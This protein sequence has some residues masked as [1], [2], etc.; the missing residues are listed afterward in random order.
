MT[1][2]MLETYWYNISM[3]LWIKKNPSTWVE[4]KEIWVKKN[5]STWVKAKQLWVKKT[6]NL[7]TMFWPQAGPYPEEELYVFTSLDVFPS[8]GNVLPKITAYVYRFIF[9]GTLTLKYRWEYSNSET[10]PFDPVSGFSTYQTY[11]PGN[12]ASGTFNTLDFIPQL[13]DYVYGRT[14]FR[15]V[16]QATDS[17]AT[18]TYETFSVPIFMGGPYWHQGAAFSGIP[19]LNQTLTW[20]TGEGRIQGT[21]DNVGYMTTIY[22]T[23]DNGVTKQY[24][25]GTA[26][27]PDYSFS[28]NYL[29]EFALTANDIGY[30][31]HASTYSIYGDTFGP[32]EYAQK[33]LIISASKKVV[34]PPGPFSI[35]SFTKGKKTGNLVNSS[36]TLTLNYSASTDAD[37]YQFKIER[38]VNG[39]TWFSFADYFSL[40]TATDPTTSITVTDSNTQ[41]FVFYRAN[42]RALNASQINTQSTNINV[43]ATGQPPGAPTI[44]SASVSFGTVQ[45]FYTETTNFGSGTGIYAHDFAYKLSTDASFSSWIYSPTSGGQLDISGLTPGLTYNF[46]IRSYNDDNVVGPESNVITVTIPAQPGALTNTEAKTW[47][48]A[49][50][51]V[52]F[53][54][55]NNT[56]GVYY[57]ATNGPYVGSSQFVRSVSGVFTGLS[58]N[59]SYVRDIIN[60]PTTDDQYD[61]ILYAQNATVFGDN[62][63][64]D[65]QVATGIYPNGSDKSFASVPTFSNITASGFTANYALFNTSSAIIDIRSGG[66][67][68]SGYPQTL[69]QSA[70]KAGALFTHTPSF[71]LP[72][73][74]NYTFFVTPYYQSSVAPL[75]LDFGVQKSANVSTRYRFS[76]GKTLHVSSNGHIGL[77]SGSS[78]FTL[79][80]PGKNI[81][82][83]ARDLQQWYLAEYSDNSHY[84]LYFRS[85]LLEGVNSAN[86]AVDYQIKFYNNPAINYCDVYMVRVGTN[87][88]VPSIQRGFYGSGNSDYAG[89]DGAS[90]FIGTG[91]TT[92]IYFGGTPMQT[93]GVPWTLLNDNLWD[94]IQTW[95]YPNTLDDSFTSVVTAANQ[96]L[97]PT[98]FIGSI[99][100]TENSL[101]IPLTGTYSSYDYNIRTGSYFGTIVSSSSG[102]TT[103]I[104]VTGLSSN[105]T[106]YITVTPKNQFAQTGTSA[107]T[108]FSTTVAFTSPTISS[109]SYNNSN[110][111]WTVN[112]TGGSGPFYQLWYQTSTGAAAPALSGTDSSFPDASSSSTSSTTDVL[113]ASAGTI[114]WWWV[115]SAKTLNGTGAGNV[116]AWSGPVTAPPVNTATPTLTGTAKVGQTL[117]YGA[118]TW[119]NARTYDLRLYR[120]TQFVSTSETLA[121]SSTSTSATYL[122]PSSDFTD[123]LNRKYYRTYVNAS[124][125]SFSS[126]LTGGTEI[127]P[128][129]N[130]VLYTITFDSKSGS[131]VAAL[132]QATEGGSIAKPTDP[133][134]SGFN[135][136]GWS[137][138]DGGTTAVTWP[139]TPSSSETLYAIWLTPTPTP[140][141]TRIQAIGLGNTSPGPYITFTFTSTNAASLS[142]MLYR[143][144]DSAT[145]PWTALSARLIR[146]ITSPFAIDFSSRTG[147]TSNWYYVDVIPYSGANATGTAGTLRTSNSRRGT[148]TTSATVYGA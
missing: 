29:Y 32:F 67:S 80:S 10:G 68:I 15:F 97:L 137:T 148:Q 28:D 109:V 35:T 101:S 94:V 115:R 38:S 26:I 55:G 46:K 82:I 146:D 21:S 8:F 108:T 113:A 90:F 112:Y 51:T 92:R 69:S 1:L 71:S 25:Y 49:S 84:Y 66:S 7:W 20:N 36:R 103:P 77:D 5:D 147:T 144:A 42:M 4:A 131:A 14:Y 120:G 17:S 34:G 11:Q 114:Y 129:T 117:T 39:S 63:G 124:N 122:I 48:N 140:D 19:T 16:M 9:D 106:Y 73:S 65:T 45:L 87:V 23:N 3:A 12:P 62:V 100:A 44:T 86:D 18:A 107:Q 13:S 81:A 136:G 40:I 52:G 79:M 41:N 125:P 135:F 116:T 22:R 27:E 75:M 60:F 54:T 145:G 33:S 74:T 142:I 72:D 138:T 61:I 123:P 30:T 96:Y 85:Y 56:T 76:F 121:A 118:G 89:T 105:T 127:G 31:Y 119:F 88:S 47:S 139:R 141:V 99:T 83:L 104:S 130:I 128:L 37:Y 132:T 64:T 98:V 70:G 91:S 2:D 50:V 58:S 24:L 93:T 57:F 59:T 43:D 102:T 134:R 126:G 143:S 110:S 78:S 111:T 95:P 133:T 53:R 6:A